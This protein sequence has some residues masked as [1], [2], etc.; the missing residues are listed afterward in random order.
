MLS[1]NTRRKVHMSDEEE[2]V[3]CPG[4]QEAMA[5]VDSET[6]GKETPSSPWAGADAATQLA[7]INEENVGTSSSF[8]VKSMHPPLLCLFRRICVRKRLTLGA[9][10]NG[11]RSGVGPWVELASLHMRISS[12]QG[13]LRAPRRKTSSSWAEQ[14]SLSCDAQSGSTAGESG[15]PRLGQ[16]SLRQTVDWSHLACPAQVRR[17]RCGVGTAAKTAPSAPAHHV[18]GAT[19]AHGE[20]EATASGSGGSSQLQAAKA[21]QQGHGAHQT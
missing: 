17:S 20:R 14:S 5:Q 15:L 8:T 1:P 12:K 19:Q 10:S 18:S 7:A 4:I 21:R 13:T 11:T 2:P 3:R 9:H 6:I 16:L